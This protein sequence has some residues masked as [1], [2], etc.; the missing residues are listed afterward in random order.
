MSRS[1]KQ[2]PRRDHNRAGCDRCTNLRRHA[3]VAK[4]DAQRLREYGIADAPTC[5]ACAWAELERD[6]IDAGL[7]A[8]ECACC[9]SPKSGV[10]LLGLVERDA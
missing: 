2:T 9:L 5:A 1:R 4:L 10:R 7:E 3:I 8:H 6:C